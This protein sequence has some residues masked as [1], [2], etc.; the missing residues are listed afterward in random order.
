MGRKRNSR[1]PSQRARKAPERS[2]HRK[3]SPEPQPQSQLP[4]PLIR[5]A[6]PPFK[7]EHILVRSIATAIPAPLIKLPV[8]CARF[9]NDPGATWSA[10]NIHA[11]EI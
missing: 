10:R 6:M 5:T 3:S 2:S 9:A 7:D 4:F 11:R 8:D 1:K